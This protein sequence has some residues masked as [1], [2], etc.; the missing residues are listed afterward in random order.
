MAYEEGSMAE[1][2]GGRKWLR[3]G[4]FGCLGIL[5]VVII[6]FATM[7][8]IAAMKV[9]SEEVTEDV[10]KP[11]LPAAMPAPEEAIDVP[12]SL[13]GRVELKLRHGGFFIE[14]GEQLRVDAK[15]D[16]KACEL[17]EKLTTDEAKGWTYRL[18]FSCGGFSLMGALKQMLGGSQPTIKL[19]LP[20][21]IPISLDLDA[22]QG[23]IIGDL[24]GLWLTTADLRAEM[25]GMEIDFDKPLKEPMERLR[26]E[27]SMGGLIIDRVGNA[28]PREID[29]DFKMAGVE[30]DLNGE[31]L[32][33]SDITIN[34]RMAGASI[35]V[36]NNVIV[37]G[38]ASGGIPAGQEPEIKPP[39]LRFETS[40]EM[41]EIEITD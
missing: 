32:Q 12:S 33:D 9:R 10:L 13:P 22:L 40:I 19:Q 11:D 41:G 37:E 36:P 1:S 6:V 38:L 18:E 35:V 14:P 31:W 20:S 8:L 34:G 21:D 24:G 23:G 3:C 15:Y 25:A 27:G 39:T 29:I 17:Q 7:M 16:T 28:S 26:F 2:K 4:C 5:A 30:M